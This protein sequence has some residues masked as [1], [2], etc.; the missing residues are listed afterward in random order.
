MH[1]VQ[2]RISGLLAASTFP[3]QGMQR[4]P[5]CKTIEG[6]LHQALVEAGA[7]SAANSDDFAKVR[8]LER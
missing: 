3:L 1:S 5:G 7:I 6:D 2:K 8:S 4:N